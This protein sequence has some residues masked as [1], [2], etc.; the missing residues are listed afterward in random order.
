[1]DGIITN[2]VSVDKAVLVQSINGPAV[3]TIQGAIDPGIHEWSGRHSLS[4]ADK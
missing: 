4:M 2:R 1:M 3:T